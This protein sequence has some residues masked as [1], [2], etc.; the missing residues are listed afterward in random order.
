MNAD[1]PDGP[2]ENVERDIALA[3]LEACRGDAVRAARFCGLPVG[4][5][6]RWARQAERDEAARARPEVRQGAEWDSLSA[7]PYIPAGLVDSDEAR[8]VP[9]EAMQRWTAWTFG[10]REAA[11]YNPDH[12]HLVDA[13]IGWLWTNVESAKDGRRVVGTAEI[14]R[15]QGNRWQRERA[16]FQLREWYGE[17][18]DFLITLDACYCAGLDAWSFCALVE[19]E[20]YHCGQALDGYGAPRFNGQTGLPVW[21]IRGHDVEEFTGVVRRYGAAASS[22]GV[23]ELVAAGIAAPE[24]GAAAKSGACGVCLRLAG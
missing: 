2:F 9:D 19:H 10:H 16:S 24:I 7:A 22:A 21:A 5:V 6:R 14:P 1:A 3:A 18:I 11:L 13:R 8:F 23:A 15:G 4:D 17:E 12:A 20:L